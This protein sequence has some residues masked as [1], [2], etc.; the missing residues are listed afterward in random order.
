MVCSASGFWGEEITLPK[1][2]ENLFF[3]SGFGGANF[4]QRGAA[5]PERY[6]ESIIAGLPKMGSPAMI[7]PR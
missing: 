4:A 6:K 1:N 3:P 2:R 5:L 7:D